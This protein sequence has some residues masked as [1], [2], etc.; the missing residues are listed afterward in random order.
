VIPSDHGSGSERFWIGEGRSSSLLKKEAQ[1][2]FNVDRKDVPEHIPRDKQRRRVKSKTRSLHTFL[3]G[4]GEQATRVETSDGGQIA[5]PRKVFIIL[6]ELTDKPQPSA[7]ANCGANSITVIVPREGR[8][9]NLQEANCGRRDAAQ[10]SQC[11]PTADAVT[12]LPPSRSVLA[13]LTRLPFSI[14]RA[15]IHVTL[16]WIKIMISDKAVRTQP[17]TS[18]VDSF[19]MVLPSYFVILRS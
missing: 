19:F 7:I 5:I 12:W 13:F 10:R 17:K 16:L 6:L 9:A 14:T 11:S 8:C 4:I 18:D 3:T 15:F 1:I 2:P